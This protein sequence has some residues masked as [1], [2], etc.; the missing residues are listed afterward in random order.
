[1]TFDSEDPRWEAGEE[2][3]FWRYRGES[4]GIPWRCTIRWMSG[5]WTQLVGLEFGEVVVQDPNLRFDASGR[6]PGVDRRNN[7]VPFRP[8]DVKRVHHVVDVLFHTLRDAELGATLAAF[9]R[10]GES[11]WED[12]RGE[13]RIQSLLDDVGHSQLQEHEVGVAAA[14]YKMFVDRDA[15][16]PTLKTAQALHVSRATAARRIKE[17]REKGLLGPSKP[18]KATAGGM[19]DEGG[20]SLSQPDVSERGM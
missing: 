20:S 4:E 1:M 8:L 7:P 14:V 9:M 18:G 6:A 10:A 3:E 13:P 5:G 11:W 15:A 12:P 19:G 16:D 2:G 17:A